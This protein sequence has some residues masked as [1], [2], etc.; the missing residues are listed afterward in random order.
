MFARG[1][2]SVVVFRLTRLGKTVFQ[3][4]VC[5]VGTWEHIRSARLAVPSTDELDMLTP[6]CVFSA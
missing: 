5:K 6:L 3:E 2:P 4:G 1:V